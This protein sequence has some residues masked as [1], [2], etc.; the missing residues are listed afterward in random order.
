MASNVASRRESETNK[1]VVYGAQ[2]SSLYFT[3]SFDLSGAQPRIQEAFCSVEKT[4][5][6][7]RAYMDIIARLVSR[8]LHYLS[9]EEVA[10]LLEGVVTSIRGPVKSPSGVKFCFG[11]PDLFGKELRARQLELEAQHAQ[12]ELSERGSIRTE[13][14]QAVAG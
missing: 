5:S 13:S 10:S 8:L 11:Y 9:V 6:D 4:G 7:E 14:H 2:K 12:Q 3:F 1:V